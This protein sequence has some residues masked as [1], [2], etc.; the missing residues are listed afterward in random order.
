MA[1]SIVGLDL[2][3]SAVRGA[4]LVIGKARPVLTRFGQIEVPPGAMRDGEVVDPA[5]VGDALSRLWKQ[6]GFKTKRNIVLGVSNQKVIVRQVDLPWMAEEDLRAALEF[7]VQEFIPIPVDEAIL[8]F[9]ILDEFQGPE[10][11]RMMRLL[12]VAAQRDMID[13]MISSMEYAKLLPSVIDLAPFA[14]LRSLV[15]NYGLDQPLAAEA[16]V[17]IGAGVTNIVVHEDGRPRFVRILIIGGNNFT[18]ALSVGLSMDPAS[19]EQLKRQIAVSGMAAPPGAEQATQ[20]LDDRTTAFV[21]EIRGSLDFYMAQPDAAQVGRVLLT[22]GTS[23]LPGLA[24]KLSAVLGIPVDVGHPLQ[25]VELGSLG[26][27]TDALAEAQPLMAVAVGL[28]LGEV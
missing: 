14:L 22:G 20:I 27:P 15:S 13:Q 25:Y 10:G 16:L 8:D 24:E 6:A 3:T 2:G 17:D 23:R 5:A 9:L 26:M 7:Q 11:E 18:E 28:A 21:D 19:A 1:K 12:L 4:E